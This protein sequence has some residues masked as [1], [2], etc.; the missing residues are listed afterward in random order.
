MTIT[1]PADGQAQKWRESAKN[2]CGSPRKVC[3]QFPMRKKLSGRHQNRSE[4]AENSGIPGER[5]WPL[6][7]WSSGENAPKPI[8]DTK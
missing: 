2:T 7:A 5:P 4:T 8:L 6:V 1:A 3:R